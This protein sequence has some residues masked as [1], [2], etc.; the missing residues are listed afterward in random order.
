MPVMDNGFT[1]TVLTFGGDPLRASFFVSQRIEG[2]AEECVIHMHQLEATFEFDADARA[3]A[4]RAA[5]VL[6]NS[7]Q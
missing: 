3:A 4:S 2:T 6:V 5:G 1:T 7:M